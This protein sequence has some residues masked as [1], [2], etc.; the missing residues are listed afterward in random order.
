MHS[1][2]TPSEQSLHKEIDVYFLTTLA[3]RHRRGE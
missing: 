1:S 2:L 3:I